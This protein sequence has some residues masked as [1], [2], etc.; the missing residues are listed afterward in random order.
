MNPR[1]FGLGDRVRETI[2]GDLGTVV[3][4][5]WLEEGEYLVHACLVDF[6]GCPE[7]GEVWYPDSNSGL[8]LVRRYS[9]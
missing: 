1:I 3:S 6:D 2:S 4:I 9:R 5:G 8:N 7:G